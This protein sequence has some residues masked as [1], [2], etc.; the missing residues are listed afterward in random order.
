MLPQRLRQSPSNTFKRQSGLTSGLWD[1]VGYYSPFEHSTSRPVD[2]SELSFQALSRLFLS[3]SNLK[4]SNCFS[5][6]LSI[7]HGALAVISSIG[8]GA[9]AL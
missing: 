2:L 6:M 5:N 9:C 8:R 7:K 3:S 4:L 1:V